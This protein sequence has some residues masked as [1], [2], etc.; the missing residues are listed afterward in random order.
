MKLGELPET[1][2]LKPSPWKWIAIS[3]MGMLFSAVGVWMIVDE[4]GFKSWFCAIF[5]GAVAAVAIYMLFSGSYLELTADGFE[6]KM[7]GR[8][9]ACRWV[10]VSEFGI[11]VVKGNR[12]VSFD[13]P[14]VEIRFDWKQCAGVEMVLQVVDF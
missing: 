12:F 14:D 4:G 2:L 10:E 8:K 7:M 9:M 6:Q 11:W 3:L 13:G 1:M 5:F